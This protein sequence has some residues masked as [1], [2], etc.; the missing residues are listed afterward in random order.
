ME[1]IAPIPVLAEAYS[2]AI[3]SLVREEQLEFDSFLLGVKGAQD[4]PEEAGALRRAAG[5]A[6]YEA[7]QCQKRVEF[8]RAEAIFRLRLL[9]P[10]FSEEEL[11]IEVERRSLYLYG[12]YQKLERGISQSRWLCKRCEGRGCKRCDGRGRFYER[13]VQELISELAA[14]FF[15]SPVL[16]AFHGMGREDCDVLMLGE[17]R[18]FVLEV[19]DPRRRSGDLPAL[20]AAINA[21]HAGLISVKNLRIVGREVR[22]RIKAAKADKSYRAVCQFEAPAPSADKIQA[23]PENFQDRLLEQRTPERVSQR[24]ADLVR[25]RRIRELAVESIEDDRCTLRLRTESGTYV[26]EF[27]SGD[28]GR[29]RPSIAEVLGVPCLCARLDVLDI[30]ISDDEAIGGEGGPDKA[31]DS[32]GEEGVS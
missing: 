10:G 15:R 32:D 24:R 14:P 13:S 16:A 27:I 26:K 20:A 25:P 11:S 30:H 3:Q 23:L 6:L 28:D 9:P 12:R 5:V 7:W 29:T 2:H 31:S 4:H 22:A 1:A 21:K 8:K 19:T 18:P 17:G